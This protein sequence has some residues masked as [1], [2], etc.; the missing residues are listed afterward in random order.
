VTNLLP[1]TYD[2]NKRTGSNTGEAGKGGMF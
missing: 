2:K 1:F